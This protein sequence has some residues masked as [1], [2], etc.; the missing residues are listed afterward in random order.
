MQLRVSE[1]LSKWVGVADRNIARFFQEAEELAA[2]R[3]VTPDGR[4]LEMPLLLVIEECD[5]WARTRGEDGIHDRIQTTLLTNLDPSR[6][7]FRERTRVVG[8]DR[9]GQG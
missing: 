3:L 6:A 7:L 2:E 5:A 1:V 9:G 8:E 4:E